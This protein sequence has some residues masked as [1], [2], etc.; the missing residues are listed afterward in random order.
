M[1]IILQKTAQ[2]IENLGARLSSSE[3]D[4]QR[5]E[6]EKELLLEKIRLLQFRQFGKK[7]EKWNEDFTEVLPGILPDA[8]ATDEDAEVEVV[9]VAEHTKK[10]PGRRPLSEDLPREERL[11][12]L[13]E[14]E[15]I[16][17]IHGVLLKRIGEERS[18]ALEFVPAKCKVIAT[19][20]P[21]YLCPCCEDTDIRVAPAP[22]KLIPKS[23]STP[24]FL[25]NIVISKFLDHCPLYRQEGMYERIGVELSRGTMAEWIIRL[26]KAVTPL[27]NLLQERLIDG[28]YLSCDETP[29]RVLTEDGKQIKN[30]HYL[31]VR[32]RPSDF[33]TPIIL[34]EY[35]SSRRAAVAKEIL[36]GFKGYLQV[37]QY[38]GYD[39]TGKTVHIVRVGCWAHVRRKF[40]EAMKIMK[41]QGRKTGVPSRVLSLIKKLY[42]A[43]EAA[44]GI[45][46]D[47]RTEARKKLA[48]PILDELKLLLETSKQQIPDQSAVGKAIRYTLNAWDCLIK[49][50]DDHRIRLDN[51]I[52][53]NA[54]RPVA[55]GRKNYLF[56][57]TP[58]GARAAAAIYSLIAT[59]KAN[60]LDV[61]EYFM[62]LIEKLPAAKTLEDF[63]ALLPLKSA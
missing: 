29:L 35:A 46:P 16:C 15:K 33:G 26:G 28:E 47:E 48:Q 22:L 5:L 57:Q 53:E 17:A 12:D 24:S 21:K 59:A 3:K 34:F 20:R 40:F 60:D 42:R 51:N 23:I 58:E 13:P 39:F 55:I 43:D 10:K 37:D 62:N 31:W 38:V 44:Q 50:F 63:E 49:I 36:E 54:I 45:H 18:E 30:L 32:S 2:I 19:V 27:M 1:N 11:V 7:T 61:R 52:T 8:G 4:R 9:T 14:S 6:Q 56:C 41:S 25:T